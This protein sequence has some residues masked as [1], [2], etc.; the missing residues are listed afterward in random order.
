MLLLDEITAALPANL[1]ERVLQAVQQQGDDRAVIF[2]SHR[3]IEIAAICDRATVLRNGETVGVVDVAAGS[4]DK[5]VDLMLG[6]APPGSASTGSPPRAPPDR[7]DQVAARQ[8]QQPGRWTSPARCHLRSLPGEVL[9]VVALDGQGQ[10][11]LFDLLSGAERPAAGSLLVDGKAVSFHHPADAIRMG[12]VFVAA[13]RAEALLMQRSVRENISLPFS[14]RIRS[15]GWIDLG[16][17]R[18]KVDKAVETLQIDA[19]AGSE[20][21]RL[22]GGNQQKVTIARWVAS[23]VKTMLCFDPTRGIDIRTKTQIYTLLRDLAAAGAAILLY[24]SELK[25]VPLVCDR[26]IVIFNGEVVAEMP[27]A[28]AD[29]ATLLRAA[30]NLKAGAALPEANAAGTATARAAVEAAVEASEAAGRP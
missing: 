5:I 8:H 28:G 24:T 20:V 6:E 27:A 7:P 29:E 10:D 17:E 26:V 16:H 25:E 9:G 19:R 21:R 30:H 3:M 2:I 12:L 4:E 23:G 22:S 1:T 13:D 14:A 15:W 18:Q 11:E